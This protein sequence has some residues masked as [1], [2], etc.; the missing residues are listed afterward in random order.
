[1]WFVEEICGS[2]QKLFLF[3][4][5]ALNAV[6]RWVDISYMSE[7]SEESREKRRPERSPSEDRQK[8]TKLFITNLDGKVLRFFT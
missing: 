3:H 4:I 7:S 1:M 8:S 6:A 5:S 2:R